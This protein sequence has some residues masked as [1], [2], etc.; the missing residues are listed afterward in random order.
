MLVFTL[1]F[2]K[3]SALEQVKKKLIMHPQGW[4]N[5]VKSSFM[6]TIFK[7]ALNRLKA[8]CHWFRN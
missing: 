1:D 7:L 4:K 3:S 8:Q 6:K 5:I 2:Y